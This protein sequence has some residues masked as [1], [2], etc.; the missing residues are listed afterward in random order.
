MTKDKLKG[1]LL[2]L[3]AGTMITLAGLYQSDNEKEET[4]KFESK[5]FQLDSTYTHKLDSIVKIEKKKSDSI[6][7]LLQKE[8]MDCMMR[9][10][11][12]RSYIGTPY[13][14]GGMSKAGV[15]C[16]GLMCLAASKKASKRLSKLR[17][18]STMYA[19]LKH[20]TKPVRGTLVFFSMRG[21]GVDHVGLLTSK[22]KF[23]HSSSSRGV[24]ED[25]LIKYKR[26]IV[27]YKSV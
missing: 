7:F 18:A 26:K 14:W 22:T 17:T 15:D 5:I 13:K 11:K 4:K 10:E 1:Y 19:A 12:A 6:H 3:V 8:R 16:S 20:V 21:R 23:I 24:I 2:P 27:G 9:V 25:S